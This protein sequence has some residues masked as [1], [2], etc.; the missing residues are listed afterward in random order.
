[1]AMGW[2]NVGSRLGALVLVPVIAW[3]I[4][5]DHERLGWQLT[6][7]ILGIVILIVAVPLS[8]LIRNRPQDYGQYPDGDQPLPER[9]SIPP[10]ESERP[11]AATGNIR[12]ATS[13]STGDLTA[14]QALRTSAFWLISFGHGFTSMV[15]LAIM[16]H[17]GLLLKDQGINVQTTGWIVIVYTAVAMVFQLVGGYLGDR[18][19]KNI[20]LFVFTSIQAGAVALLTQAHSLPMFYLFAILFGIGFGGRNPLT[21]AIRGEY[22]GRASF[23]R[24]LGLSSV[25]MNVLLLVGSPFAGYLRDVQGTYSMAFLILAGLNFLGGVLFLLA[26]KPTP[27][28][29]PTAPTD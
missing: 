28:T 13:Y 8:R 18:M 6:A 27:P 1:M 2:A 24:I 4:D 5:P 16:S 12:P 26:R 10:T 29:Q 11:A 17:L 20:T 3:S 7:L 15:I 22:F 23:G 19:P 21:T 9:P 14:A 25:P